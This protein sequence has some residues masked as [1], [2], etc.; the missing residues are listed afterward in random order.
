M[1]WISNYYFPSSI[2][3]Y[4]G[5]DKFEDDTAN[6]WEIIGQSLGLLVVKLSKKY[7]V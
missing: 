4:E 2:E 7:V 1:F 5:L 6:L 3:M